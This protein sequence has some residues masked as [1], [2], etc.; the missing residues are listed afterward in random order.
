MTKQLSDQPLSNQQLKYV[1]K[2]ERMLVFVADKTSNDDLFPLF[3]FPSLRTET[4]PVQFEP[5]LTV[6]LPGCE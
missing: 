2:C 6:Y 4:N 1:E 5:V 3:F